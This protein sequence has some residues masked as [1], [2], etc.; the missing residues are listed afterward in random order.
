LVCAAVVV[1]FEN[2][3][4]GLEEEE[5]EEEEEET[6]RKVP[7]LVEKNRKVESLA[8]IRTTLQSLPRGNDRLKD[9]C[10]M[11]LAALSEIM[12]TTLVCVLK[13]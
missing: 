2:E 3:G 7:E 11:P 9:V 10:I 13:E 4:L 1:V 8:L 12:L 6:E 5:D